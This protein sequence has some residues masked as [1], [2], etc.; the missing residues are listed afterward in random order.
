GTV[1]EVVN[2]LIRAA[3]DGPTIPFGVLPIGT[4]NDF[5]DMA[6]LPRNI[7]EAAKLFAAGHTRQIDAGRVQFNGKTH[8]FDNNC[9]AA[10]EPLVTIENEKLI[11]LSGN[12]RYIVAL[13]R[14]LAKL[15]AWKM[16]I[17]WDGGGYEGPIYLLSICNSPRT[18][19]LFP[20]APDASLD[21]GL[22]DFVMAPEI[23]KI[24]VLA[25]LARLFQGTHI[26]HK[27]V[28]YGRSAH[29]SLVSEPGSPIHADGEVLTEGA[30]EIIYDILPGKITLLSP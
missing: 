25:V 17:I 15:K 11:K 1:N 19:G 20:M 13:V 7:N 27:Q 23:P 9:A 3:G 12:M 28:T 10:M 26:H 6:K 14:A 29:I 21:D 22:F 4:G 5:N 8:Y 18:G 30:T 2:G 24:T 16:K